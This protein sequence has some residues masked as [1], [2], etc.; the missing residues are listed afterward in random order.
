MS[1]VSEL[2]QESRLCELI[3]VLIRMAE[4]QMDHHVAMFEDIIKI[5]HRVRE[6]EDDGTNFHVS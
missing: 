5:V 4:D 1:H 3:L 2:N 6:M